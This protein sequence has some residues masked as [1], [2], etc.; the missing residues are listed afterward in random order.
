MANG[1]KIHHAGKILRAARKMRR[2]T[3][4]DVAEKLGVSGAN[5]ARRE[6][7]ASMTTRRFQETL[8]ALD[9]EVR[10]ADKLVRDEATVATTEA[11]PE[12]D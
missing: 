7:A 6:S 8:A 11:D 4:A 10:V 2:L 12:V 5:V 3:Q 9:F 1:L